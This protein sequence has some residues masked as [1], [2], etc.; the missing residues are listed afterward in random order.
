MGKGKLKLNKKNKVAVKSV[1]TERSKFAHQNKDSRNLKHK[2]VR[3]EASSYVPKDVDIIVRPLLKSR[4]DTA[5][6]KFCREF[7][8]YSAAIECAPIKPE[9]KKKKLSLS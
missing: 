8:K 7:A 1:S 4:D 5:I 6:R 3:G 2:Y 9:E